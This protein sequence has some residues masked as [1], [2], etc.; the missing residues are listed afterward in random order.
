MKKRNPLAV[1]FLP[2]ITFG[3][4]YFVRF[5]K[6]K[7]EMKFQGA[8]IPTAWFLIIPFANLYFV[9]KFG[10]G[11]EMVTK[12]HMS[13]IACFLWIFLFSTIGMAITQSKINR[14]L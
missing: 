8:S 4:Y 11:V 10:Q 1:F 12:K 9:W 3:I 14:T 13:A 2:V 5:V 7:E 6:V